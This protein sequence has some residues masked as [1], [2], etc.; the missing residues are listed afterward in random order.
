MWKR[1]THILL[2]LVLALIMLFTACTEQGSDDPFSCY[3]FD[4]QGN[5]I[6]GYERDE[7]G[8]WYLFVPSSQ[9]LSELVLHYEG[10]I[11]KTSSGDLNKKTQTLSNAFETNGDKITLT[12]KQRSEITVVVMQSKLPSVQ[13]TLKDTTLD[14]I[15]LDKDK[16]YKENTIFIT[17]PI[18]NNNLTVED[19]VEIKGRGN[20]T[21]TLYEKKAYQIKFDEK[22]SVL[23]MPK[24]KKWVL[25]SNA[26]D[27]SMIRNQLIYRMA[28]QMDMPYVPSFEYID[29][30]ID[31]EY[32]GTYLIGEK[33]ELGSSR[34]HLSDSKGV[35]F[36][37]DEGFYAEE[38]YWFLSDY[39]QRH[40]AL[41]ESV[42][43]DDENIILS[44]MNEFSES[45]DNFLA[46][47]YETPSSQITIEDL[48][49]WIDVDSFVKYYLINEYS[50]N[51]EGF[52]SSFY[53]YKDGP[54]D[55]I[56]L[57]PIWD[58]DTCIGLD[59]TVN[60]ESFGHGHTLFSYLLAVPEFYQ[61][62]LELKDTYMYLFTDM[63]SNID[64]LYDE[65]VDSAEMNYLRWDVLG[66]TNP[67]STTA[68]FCDTYEDAVDSVR[69]WL[70]GRETAFIVPKVYTATCIVS[71]DCSQMQL[72][73]HDEQEH[74]GLRFAV[75]SDDNAQDDLKWYNAT[76]NNFG[77]WCCTVDLTQ[78]NSSGIYQITVYPTD[79]NEILGAGRAYIS[80]Q[81]KQ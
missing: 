10:N 44:A 29:L 79:S 16:K 17:D 15:H 58:F 38:K 34:L 47:M 32:L 4:W 31:G 71:D 76:Q 64:I 1:Q 53:W 40:F 62:T 81:P 67:K 77:V 75:W 22:T 46:Y 61:R 11:K 36:E 65:I 60:T 13:I 41:K 30:W 54:D 19:S 55:V 2:V 56:H 39:L 27:D 33:V 26:S 73:F 78:H 42:E 57:G 5:K 74:S 35:L 28:S 14:T 45:V 48:S 6:L 66:K 9:S 23:G 8:V 25:L 18:G 3:T 50:L 59:G 12:T 37:H 80:Q 63:T 70:E 69:R 7:D 49:A 68:N 21:W 24:A 52:V 51:K 43:E 20:S 72:Y